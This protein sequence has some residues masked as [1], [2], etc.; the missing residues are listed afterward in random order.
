MPTYVNSSGD[1]CT[2]GLISAQDLTDIATF[3]GK[4]FSVQFSPVTKQ[5]LVTAADFNNLRA[6]ILNGAGSTYLARIPNPVTKG[7]LIAATTT[8]EAPVALSFNIPK[9][10]T[11]T[12]TT[13]LTGPEGTTMIEIGS[14]NA[15]FPFKGDTTDS[16]TT[17]T[18]EKDLITSASFEIMKDF[19]P[20][21]RD[22]WKA[23][24]ASYQ[25]NPPAGW[26]NISFERSYS[27]NGPVDPNN[28]ADRANQYVSVNV[29]GY[30]NVPETSY[31]TVQG[32]TVTV[33]I[34][35]DGKI[36]ILIT[37]KDSWPGHATDGMTISPGDPEYSAFIVNGKPQVTINFLSS[38]SAA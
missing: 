12:G 31:E 16:Y 11:A 18:S 6:A 13:V 34:S 36:T 30:H 14:A 15:F 8:W 23:F 25:N 35:N 21:Q 3:Y 24:E 28:P 5:S 9:T 22:Q 32:D 7:A 2:T 20:F 37:Y 19:Q 10:V 17:Y 4:T 26:S 27:D 29:Y 33:T 38:Y 1:I